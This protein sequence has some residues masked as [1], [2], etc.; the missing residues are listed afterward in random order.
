MDQNIFIQFFFLILLCSWLLSGIKVWNTIPCKW[1]LV[2]W[3]WCLDKQNYGYIIEVR[4]IG[5]CNLEIPSESGR[6][7][8]S[9]WHYLM[10][11][12]INRACEEGLML[13]GELV[14]IIADRVKSI[15]QW[16]RSQVVL[17]FT[18]R[19]VFIKQQ[20]TCQN[21]LYKL[22]SSYH[23]K[24]YCYRY[25]IADKLHTFSANVLVHCIVCS[26]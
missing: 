21:T 16:L 24:V 4:F 14:N 18:R 10:L 5:G 3:G 1:Y 11:H 6:Q 8:T 12:R 15:H 22:V 19:V 20:L 26:S 9:H 2:V 13:A 23:G 17:D 7:C 25:D